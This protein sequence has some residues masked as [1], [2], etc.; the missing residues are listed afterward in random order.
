VRATVCAVTYIPGL[1][2]RAGGQ[3]PTERTTACL[4][5]RLRIREF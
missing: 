4:P 2:Y 5:V 1:A 3:W